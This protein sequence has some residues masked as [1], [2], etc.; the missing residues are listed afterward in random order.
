MAL[1]SYRQA[2][3]GGYS[4]LA[5]APVIYDKSEDIRELLVDEI[6]RAHTIQAASYLRPSWAIIP[7]SA[8]AAA[9]AAFAPAAAPLSVTDSTLLR[10]LTTSDL[11][12]QL[13]PRVWDWSQG[14]P[15]GGVA[16][17]RPWLD[18]LEIGRAHV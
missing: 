4:M 6:R 8:R 5:G 15:V 7:D 2:G 11:H 10:V 9:R 18:S 17:L 14:R 16:A 13:E 1:N 12:G 3:G